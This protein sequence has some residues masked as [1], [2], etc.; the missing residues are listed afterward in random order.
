MDITFVNKNVIVCG[1]TQG[2]GLSV[3]FEMAKSKA[4][5][6][7]IARNEEKLK[8]VIKALPNLSNRNHDYICVDFNNPDQLKEKLTEFVKNNPPVHIL[9]NNTGGPPAGPIVDAKLEDFQK[10]LTNHLFCNQI[11]VQAVIPGMK[12]EGYGRIINIVSTSVKQPLDNLGVSNTTR[13]AVAGWAK[14]LSNELAPHK[15]TVNNVLPGPTRTSRLA[16]IIE[17]RRKKAN[18]TTEE[19][20]KDYLN[21]VP[22]KRFAEPEELAYAV[23]FLASPQASYITGHS[24]PVDG[25]RI[26][27]L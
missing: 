5:V 15:I 18:Q 6:T 13:A 26:K 7:L 23:V 12:L 8:Q 25:G 2:I 20:E 14:T 16:E 19:A 4:H 3:A 11:L 24:L 17:G 21:D 27:G 9:V 22:M 1:S 10:S